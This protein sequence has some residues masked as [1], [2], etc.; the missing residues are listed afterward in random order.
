MN[1]LVNSFSYLC[2]NERIISNQVFFWD[3]RNVEEIIWEE[4]E[5]DKIWDE[6]LM[7]FCDFKR[8][9]NDFYEKKSQQK[10][11]DDETWNQVI[12]VVSTFRIA[13]QFLLDWFSTSKSLAAEIQFLFEQVGK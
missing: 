7:K 3:S 12:R 1:S 10:F 5:R 8:L 2:L 13:M 9:K 11:V 6:V 4:I